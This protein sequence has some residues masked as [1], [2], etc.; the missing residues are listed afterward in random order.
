MLAF[1]ALFWKMQ[2]GEVKKKKNPL[3]GAQS[4][5]YHGPFLQ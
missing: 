1:I 3:S 4:N 5:L 2:F